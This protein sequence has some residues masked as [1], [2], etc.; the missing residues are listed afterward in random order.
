MIGTILE[1]EG[2]AVTSE[3]VPL[4]DDLIRGRATVRV[5]APLARAREVVQKY[6]DYSEFMPY[7][8]SSH[9]VDRDAHVTK[10]YMQVAALNGLVKMGAELNMPN[11]PVKEGDWD[12]YESRF[13]S[14]NVRDF[15]AIWRMKAIDLEHSMVSL[16]VFLLPKL[17]LP[18]STLNHENQK[19]AVN[20]VMA[21]RDRIEKK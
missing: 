8:H 4:A 3:A 13:G 12:V 5:D 6:G 9:V 15:K 14:G 2:R 16:E 20:G 19:G 7:Y 18:T 11:L 1:P 17:P 21:M 10:V